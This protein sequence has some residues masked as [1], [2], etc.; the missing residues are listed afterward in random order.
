MVRISKAL[1]D[2]RADDALV[3]RA[4][5]AELI[6]FATALEGPSGAEDLLAAAVVNAM[7]SPRW[8]AIENKR[9]Y[10]FRAVLHEA[11]RVRRSMDRRSRREARVAPA[12][13]F[14]AD[15]TD[16]DVMTALGRLTLRQR[17]VVFFTYWADMP[18]AEV[19]REMGSS[20]RTVERELAASKRRLEGLLS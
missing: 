3:Y 14:D 20:L 16:I 15:T 13:R 11:L 9:A 7:E 17:A 4:H 5:A 19:A 12:E 18:P 10:L 2:A 1:D 8:R 6:R